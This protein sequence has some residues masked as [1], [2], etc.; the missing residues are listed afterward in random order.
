MD[1]APCNGCNDTLPV[2]GGRRVH[3]DSWEDTSYLVSYHLVF[4]NLECLSR[5]A[6]N[7]WK[8]QNERGATPAE[9]R[10]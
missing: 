5:W 1:A 10:Q 4:C 9:S 8:K 2:F 3:L 7:E 6:L